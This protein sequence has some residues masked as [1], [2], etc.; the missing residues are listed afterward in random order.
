VT[1]LLGVREEAVTAFILKTR[2][3]DLPAAV[4][5][6]ALLCLVDN[7]ASTL[8][9]STAPSTRIAESVAGELLPGDQATLLACGERASVLGA[10]FANG[11][12]ANAYDIDDCG[13]Y[14]W[15]HPGA[16]VLPAAL[17][18][19]EK[20]G[21]GGPAVLA[22]T[23]V[24]Y[25]IMFRAG[26]IWHDIHMPEYRACGTWGSIGCAA[27]GANLLGLS[28]LQT[29]HALGIAE[30]NTP[31]LP[32]LDAVIEPAMVK[33]GIGIGALNG[34]LSAE[35]AARGFTGTRSLLAREEYDEWVRDLGRHFILPNGM[36]WKEYSCCLWAHAPLLAVD[37]L[38]AEHEFAAA[39]VTRIVI[40]TYP[41]ALQLHIVHPETTEEA[42]FSIAW[43]VAALLVD[44]EVATEQVADAR[45]GD[46]AINVLADKIEFVASDEYQCLYEGSDLGRPD[47]QDAA[48]VT[49]E[50]ADGRVLVSGLVEHPVYEKE[51]GSWNRARMERKVRWLLRHLVTPEGMDQ[52]LARLWSFERLGDVREFTAAVGELL[53]AGRA[54]AAEETRPR[55]P[56]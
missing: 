20:L 16:Q 19:G 30:Y 38:M 36:S 17:A 37:R 23:V 9:G 34:L 28:P 53:A 50:L 6:W 48:C 4:R 33:H 2:W 14:T 46:P 1:V 49:I 43:P 56:Q 42:Q 25:E 47:S 29:R 51:A 24:G 39:D 10:A 41:D 35:L 22:A 7:V 11:V 3:E 13:L 12:A 21:A 31:S 15:G 32:M 8:S 5:E 44:G 18:M 26:R 45:L 40:E 55:P 27:I 54:A 52:L